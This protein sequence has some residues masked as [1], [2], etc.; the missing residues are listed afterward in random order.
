MGILKRN[1]SNNSGKENTQK[2]EKKKEKCTV[3]PSSKGRCSTCGK[4]HR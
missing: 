2:P 4:R 1:K 3:P